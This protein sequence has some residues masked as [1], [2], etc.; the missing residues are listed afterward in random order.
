[1]LTFYI[2]YPLKYTYTIHYTNI[3]LHLTESS[4]LETAG[5]LVKVSLNNLASVPSQEVKKNFTRRAQSF[6]K[7]CSHLHLDRETTV[8][9]GP[10]NHPSNSLLDGQ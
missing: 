5:K 6:L 10:L 7:L 2:F 4:G 9:H 3:P 1:M 8:K